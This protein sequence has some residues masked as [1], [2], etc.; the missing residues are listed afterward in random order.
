MSE[1]EARELTSRLAAEQ[2]AARTELA[3]VYRSDWWDRAIA[4]EIA[5]TWQLA[6]EWSG[7][8]PE[9]VRAEARMRDELR[10]RY[11]VDVDVDAANT[12]PAAVRVA[13]RARHRW[14]S[15]SRRRRGS[16]RAISS[17]SPAS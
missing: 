1:Q 10:A 13:R 3:G 4:A 5:N 11:G 12:D 7:E 14:G 2:R 9:A 17:G 16:P 8:D 15:R 6:R